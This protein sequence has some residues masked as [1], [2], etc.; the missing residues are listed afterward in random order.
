MGTPTYELDVD[1]DIGLS[2]YIYHNGDDDT[3]IRFE[4]DEITI[5]AGGRSF[6]NLQE[7][8]TDKLVINNG[9]LDIDL[10][11]KG[12]NDANLIR[13]EAEF[14]SI[15]F[16]AS[17]GAGSDNNFFVSGSINSKGTSERGTAAF[18][19]DLVASG[20]FNASLG[21]SGSLTRLTDVT[22]ILVATLPQ[23]H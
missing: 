18:G 5:S 8:S 22:V 13:T 11:V 14:D 17:S 6:I 20:A 9:G 3:F 12:E 4:D 15:Y 19:G 23:P 21:L 1:G 2:E 10:Q 16:G 7:A